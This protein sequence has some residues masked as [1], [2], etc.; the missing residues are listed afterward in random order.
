[1]GLVFAD[2]DR[3][4]YQD[5]IAGSLLYR[6]PGGRLHEEWKRSLIVDDD[7]DIFFA[8]D[9]NS[10]QLSDLIGI[11]DSTVYWIEATDEKATAWTARPVGQVA[12]GGRT[13]GHALARLIPGK[14]PQLIFTRG[15]NLYVLEIPDDPKNQTWPLHR[16]ST[17]SEEEGIAVGDIDRDGDLDIAAVSTDGHHVIWL[18]NPG[19][20]SNEWKVHQ[21]GGQ[22][23]ADN[24]QV[25]LDRIALADL[26]GDGHL[27]IVATEEKQ[28]WTIG[29]HLYWFESP[30]NI[31]EGEWRRHIIAT[32][33]SLNSMQVA[34]IDGDG[35][36][37][38]VVA[39]HTDQ[40]TDGAMDNLTTVYL[41]RNSGRT[42][43]PILVERG[44]HSSHLGAQLVDLDNDG[45]MEIVSFAW[46]QYKNVNLWK[47]T[48]QGSQQ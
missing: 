7:M 40:K 22:D 24:S 43:V 1:M 20:L 34:D 17:A 31:R 21:V 38:I 8:V 48:A 46:H 16:I 26:K 45:V 3:D 32:Q 28:D 27:D 23:H 14:R 18:E 13:Q 5:V 12:S 29:A 42:W 9:V 2:V 30:R 25:W 47:K 39:E 19:S 41:N 15:K 37:D 6:N 4:G 35:R 36:I 44:S 33:R 11:K 10:N